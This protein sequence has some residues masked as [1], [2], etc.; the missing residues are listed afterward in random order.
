T[1]R[2][3]IWVR[4][5]VTDLD[6]EQF[7]DWLDLVITHELTHIFHLDAAGGVGRA[8]RSVFGRLPYSWPVFSND[9]LPRWAVEGLAVEFETRGTGSGRTLGSYNEMIVRTAVIEDRL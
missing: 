1:N 6:I 2:I 5:P 7:R 9:D 8:L 4:A 3:N